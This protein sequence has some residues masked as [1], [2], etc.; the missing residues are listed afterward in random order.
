MSFTPEQQDLRFQCLKLADGD[1]TKAATYAAF[2]F[3]SAAV[4]GEVLEAEP[5]TAKAKGAKPKADE[6]TPRSAAE[7]VVAEDALK[8]EYK[9]VQ[10]AVMAL[11]KA[12]G[13]QAVVDLLK[14]FD[15]EHAIKLPE[16]N[17][18]AFIAA[19]DAGIG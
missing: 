5:V 12:K 13:R 16:A 7:V 11:N 6:P 18:P 9:D 4:V 17:W 3:G 10:V 14:T 19:A 8:V 1:V 15:V 2:V